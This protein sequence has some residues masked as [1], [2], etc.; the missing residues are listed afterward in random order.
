MTGFSSALYAGEVM[1]RRLKPLRHRLAYRMC[2]FLIDLDEAPAMDRK[3]RLFGFNRPALFS[4]REEDHGPREKRP[5]ALRQWIDDLLAANGLEAGGR[6]RLFCLPRLFGYAFNPLTVWFCDAPDGHLQAV[7][8]EVRNTFGQKHHYLVP[9]TPGETEDG[10]GLLRQKCAKNFYVSPFIEMALD[11]HFRVRL[12]DDRIAVSIRET[13]S[14]GPL[15]QAA[16]TGH[17]QSLSD[18]SLAR[19]A[20]AFPFM[21]LKVMAG[22]H[23]EALKLWV[24]GAKLVPRPPAP[25]K[26]VSFGSGR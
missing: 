18:A 10:K 17:R 24:K 3:L 4:F 8:Y 21:T 5:G 14:D 6:V 20:I 22:I 26:T 11:Y 23:W 15:L 2:Y 19:T 7:L 13:D 1:H 9:V 12:P 16:F 25:E